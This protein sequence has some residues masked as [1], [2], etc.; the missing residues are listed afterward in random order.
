MLVATLFGLGVLFLLAALH[1]YLTYP[2]SLALLKNEPLPTQATEG[3]GN[4]EQFAIC[5]C[6]YNEEGVIEAKIRNLLAL[7][8]D[9]PGLEILVYVDAATDATAAILQAYSDRITVVISSE[10]R[11]KTHGMNRL[12]AMTDAT[13][14]VF[15]DA[16]VLLDK[17]VLTRLATYFKNPAIGCVCG[18]LRYTNATDST[19]AETGSLYWRIEQNVKR[20]E[21]RWGAV[22]GADGSLFAIRRALHRPPPDHIIDDMYVSFHVLFQGF[23]VIQADDVLAFEKSVSVSG[24][25][26]QRKI[27]IACQAFNVH[28]LMWP[29]LR[30]MAPLKLYMYISH[31]LMRWFSIY[32]LAA[33]LLCVFGALIAASAALP[34]LAAIAL[35]CVGLLA[36]YF[37]KIT[38][39]SQTVDVLTAFTGVGIG[40]LHSLTGRLYQTWKPAASIRK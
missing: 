7:R 37:W 31:K 16:N 29:H 2:L 18:N 36:G 22:M 3:G 33:S 21:T 14:V 30:R 38:P 34:A 1:P 12:V 35:L 32:F 13:V 17:Y 25:E 5:T 10:R 19:V 4:H 40:I 15:T 39:L 20:L 24:E 8:E 27:R 6:A 9:H 23:R 28:R 11:G 26:F